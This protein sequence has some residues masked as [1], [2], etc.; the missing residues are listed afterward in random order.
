MLMN[1]QFKKKKAF[2]LFTA[3]LIKLFLYSQ[4]P[5][6]V[7]ILNPGE[8]KFVFISTINTLDTSEL[9][10][11]FTISSRVLSNGK[12]KDSKISHIDTSSVI[13]QSRKQFLINYERQIRLAIPIELRK[14]ISLN[15]KKYYISV[16]ISKCAIYDYDNE[17]YTLDE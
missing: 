4:E 5:P 3:L 13:Y 1:Y 11:T 2:L 16:L 8:L 15:K 7:T 14:R 6:R 12:L 9:S 17:L 10:K